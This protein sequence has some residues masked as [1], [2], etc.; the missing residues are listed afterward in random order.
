MA[1]GGRF[2]AA[3]VGWA[4]YSWWGLFLGDLPTYVHK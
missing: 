2:R 1:V 4:G 3:M